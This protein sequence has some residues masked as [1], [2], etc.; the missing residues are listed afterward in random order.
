MT[1]P[2]TVH[3]DVAV[4]CLDSKTQSTIGPQYALFAVMRHL[5]RRSLY[6]SGVQA[7]SC[8][9]WRLCGDR[10]A[11]TERGKKVGQRHTGPL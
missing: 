5:R 6:R 4:V 3:L 11:Q 1:C 10:R 8:L 2:A 9:T 7:V